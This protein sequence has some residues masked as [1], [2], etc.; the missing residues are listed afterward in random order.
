MASH[1][2]SLIFAEGVHGGADEAFGKASFCDA[3]GADHGGSTGGL[4]F[5]HRLR[6]G[7]GV[8][9]VHHHFRAFTGQLQRNFTAYAAA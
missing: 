5:G 8:Q 7:F 2:S 9:V 1:C 6:G 4:D 3:A